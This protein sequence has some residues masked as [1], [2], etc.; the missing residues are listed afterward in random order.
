M[1]VYRPL[2]RPRAV[3]RAGRP[4]AVGLGGRLGKLSGA[5]DM[6]AG[7]NVP[8]VLLPDLPC[9][10]TAAPVFRAPWEAQAFAMAVALHQQGLFTWPEWAA[11]L[12]AEIRKSEEHTSELQSLMRISYA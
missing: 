2:R 3:G 12:T 10:E 1:A 5:R 6:T 11:A 4:D 8:V 7:M 9:D